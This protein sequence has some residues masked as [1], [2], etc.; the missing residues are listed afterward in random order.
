M[1]RIIAS[2]ADCADNGG[3]EIPVPYGVQLLG[4]NVWNLLNLRRKP[5]LI[6]RE[7]DDFVPRSDDKFVLVVKDHSKGGTLNFKDVEIAAV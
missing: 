4:A 2:D 1:R 3:V 6:Q 5:S 7:F